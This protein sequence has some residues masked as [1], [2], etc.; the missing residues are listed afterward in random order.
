M[1]EGAGSGVPSPPDGRAWDLVV[2][3]G[4]TAGLVGSQIAASTGASVLLVERRR[5]GGDC[6]WTGCVPSKALLASAAA[7]AEARAAGRL[8]VSTAGVTVDFAAVRRHV[9]GAVAA[10]EPVDSAPALERAGVRV[11]LGGARFTGPAG[12]DVAGVPV[13]FRAALLATGSVPALPGVPGLAEAAPL[14]TDSVW[15]LAELPDR[16]VVLGGG[17]TGCELAQAFARL[18]SRVVLAEQAPRLLA[19]EDPEAADL[20]TD[21]LRADGVDVRLGAAVSRVRAGVVELA[22]TE[23]GYDRLLVAA[24]RR[25]VTDCGP[26]AAGIARTGTGAVRVDRTLRTTA[27]RV[28]AAGDVTEHPR[29]T[30]VAGVHGALA[31]TNAVLGLRRRVDPVVPRVT[32]TSPEL[33]AVGAAAAPGH[34]VRTVRHEHLD[35]AVAEGRTAGFTRLVVDG[36]GRVVG[37][38]IVGPRAGESLAELTLAVRHRMRVGALVATMHAYPTF[39]DGVWNAAIADL[40]ARLGSGPA[41]VAAGGLRRARRLLDR[42]G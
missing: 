14:T 29:Y 37:G 19:G 9:H 34:T 32:F 16:L 27:P 15:E 38:T 31:A 4:G 6:L 36:R 5:L 7:A 2:L 26:D 11:A 20:V 1:G 21:A 39:G 22:G 41:A 13:R 25:P 8:G 23:L 3:G 30:H 42:R 18:G 40:R 17:S 28:W 33:A 10:I 24:G 12:L 35:R